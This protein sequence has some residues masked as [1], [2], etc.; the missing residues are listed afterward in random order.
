MILVAGRYRAWV[1]IGDGRIV[2]VEPGQGLAEIEI[3]LVEG[4]DGADVFPVAAV[5]EGVDPPLVDHLGDHVL[6][7]VG[8]VARERGVQD[9]AIEYVDA[10]GSRQVVGVAAQRG[11]HRR[12]PWLLDESRDAPV[13]RYFHDAEGTRRLRAHRRRGHR[14]FRP[15]RHM[16]LQ[17]P[18]KIHLVELVARKNEDQAVRIGIQVQEI[19]PHRVGRAL[20][21][22]HAARALFR[23]QDLHEP[24][25][26]GIEPVAL[27]DVPVEGAA[28]ELG[29][30]ED[31]A[32][33]GIEAIADGDVHQPVLARQ[34]H[35]RLGPV[36]GER[37]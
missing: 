3:G 16:L 30:Q 26:E 32:Q 36:L 20:I 13:V 4:T 21:P 19:L 18:A 35:G 34:G 14:D 27:L 15:G 33:V 9:V 6:A 7:E 2:E 28:V 22:V 1:K 24:G 11:Q 37:E 8:L 23:G 17:D 10:H 25:R 12:V 29:E 5:A 31:P